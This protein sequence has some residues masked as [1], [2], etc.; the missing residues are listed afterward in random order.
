MASL[1]KV[2]M[3]GFGKNK[4]NPA[5]VGALFVTVIFSSYNGGYLNNYEVDTI[6]SATPLANMTASG[7]AISYDNLV[8]PYGSLLDFF[9]GIIPFSI[10]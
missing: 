2:I 10:C 8:K 3:G 5:L 7:Y 4:F 1:S 6:S 9:V